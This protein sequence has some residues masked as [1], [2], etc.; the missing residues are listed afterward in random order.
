MAIHRLS[1][2]FAAHNVTPPPDQYEITIGTRRYRTNRHFL[3]RLTMHDRHEPW[4]DA[5]YAA[6]LGVKPGAIVDVGVIT[7]Q[8]MMKMLALDPDRRYVGFEPQL[9]CCFFVDQFIRRN[10]LH[11]HALLPIGLSNRTGLVSLLKRCADADGA[12]STVAGF[13]PDDFYADTQAIYVAKG[14]DVIA[15]LAI[16]DIALIK[17]DVEGGEL[18]VI[19]GFTGT[20]ERWSP[21]LFFE[22]L[23]HFLVATGQALDAA[24]VAFR[25][26]RIERMERLLRG[27]GYR[28][29]NI[30]PDRPV[31]EVMRIEPPVSS[32]L[33]ITDYVAAHRDYAP[34]LLAR[35]GPAVASSGR[36]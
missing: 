22:V 32:D 19:E 29:F 31:R 33:T 13:R 20:L 8:T 21:F 28:I 23:N 14:D 30:V 7:G 2:L 25:D 15:S 4:L 36:T 34:Q 12:A 18:E 9:D 17:I 35:M 16:E 3:N 6:A 26:G 1:K 27:L 11:T 5:P 24:M 10:Q